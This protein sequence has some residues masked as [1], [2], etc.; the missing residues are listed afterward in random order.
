MRLALD[1]A[2]GKYKKGYQDVELP[3]MPSRYYNQLI[4]FARVIRGE[5]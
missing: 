4:D 5:K 2:R 1:R 3:E